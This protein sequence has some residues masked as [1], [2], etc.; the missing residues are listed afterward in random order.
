LAHGVA[1]GLIFGIPLLFTMEMWWTGATMSRYELA[2]LVV[3]SVVIAMAFDLFIG[4][5]DHDSTG[6]SRVLDATSE[7]VISVALATVIAT[8]VLLLT[9]R[10]GPASDTDLAVWVGR[11]AAQVLPVSI[12]VAVANQVIPRDSA[13]TD[14]GTPSTPK[15]STA[16]HAARDLGAAVAGALLV[17]LNVAPTDEVRRIGERASAAEL[18]ALAVFSLVA[19]ELIVFEA[20]WA[21]QSKRHAQPGLLQ[22]PWVETVI[23]Y[24]AALLVSLAILATFSKLPSTDSLIPLSITLGLPAA[25]GA[26]AGRLAV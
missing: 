23:S 10:I 21:G 20:G 17:S 25:L 19:T 16:K 14:S 2:A 12:G 13:S 26:A 11:I 8:F 18:V 15:M 3:S 24:L 4:F 22:S 5:G 7:G 6:P 1:G 9:G